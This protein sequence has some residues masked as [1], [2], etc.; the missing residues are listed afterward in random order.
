M[1]YAVSEGLE[2][3][4]WFRHLLTEVRMV[5]RSLGGVDKESWKRSAI[6]FTDSDSWANT[7]KK[8]VG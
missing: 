6:A 1:D 5:R 8:N 7:V 3:A 2:S 4:Q